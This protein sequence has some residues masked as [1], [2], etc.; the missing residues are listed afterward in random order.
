MTCN[1]WRRYRYISLKL[2]DTYEHV[3]KDPI[4][5]RITFLLFII[6]M[7]LIATLNYYEETIDKNKQTLRVYLKRF[8]TMRL[9]LKDMEKRMNKLQ[10]KLDTENALHHDVNRNYNNHLRKIARKLIW[11]ENMRNS[12]G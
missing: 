1:L 10:G 3:R 11:R 9:E 4:R 12:K 7:L 2:A 8:H 5:L 6:I